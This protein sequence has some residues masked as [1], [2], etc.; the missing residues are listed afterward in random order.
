MIHLLIFLYKARKCNAC[1]SG[2]N[3]GSGYCHKVQ[4]DTHK[5]YLFY[6]SWNSPCT[7]YLG[8]SNILKRCLLFIIIMKSKEHLSLSRSLWRI[9]H[10][11]FFSVMQIYRPSPRPRCIS[12]LFSCWPAIPRTL[13]MRSLP[14]CRDIKLNNFY[15]RELNLWKLH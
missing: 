2:D 14:P 13:M 10:L 3:I 7:Y 1:S 4:M 15:F 5:V 9:N 11:N 6:K 12:L 8:L